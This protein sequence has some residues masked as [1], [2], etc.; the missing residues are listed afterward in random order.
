M[1]GSVTPVVEYGELFVDVTPNYKYEELFAEDKPIK[2]HI[3]YLVII[4]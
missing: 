2:T 4:M 3:V 1:I